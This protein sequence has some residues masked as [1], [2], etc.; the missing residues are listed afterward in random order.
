MF[1]IKQEINEFFDWVKVDNRIDATIRE[2]AV[3]QRMNRMGQFILY[4]SGKADWITCLSLYRERDCI[5]KVIKGLK[6]ELKVLPLKTH[7][8]KT[9]RGYLFIAF[10]SLALRSRLLGLIK[11]SDVLK[12]YS[13]EGVLLELEKWRMISR[14]WT[15]CH[16]R[17]D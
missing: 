8:E 12:K 3:Y 7:S 15:D 17:D 6:N 10:L 4:H 14:R 5:E 16:D 11:D 2:Y 9:T 1:W 13:V